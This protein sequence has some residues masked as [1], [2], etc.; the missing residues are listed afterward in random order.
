MGFLKCVVINEG[1]FELYDIYKVIFEVMVGYLFYSE[2]DIE[3]LSDFFE[4]ADKFVFDFDVQK[5]VMNMVGMFL[6]F[7][8]DNKEECV[9]V[10]GCFVMVFGFDNCYIK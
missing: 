5:Q 3:L 6:F 7:E 8:E 4:G 9:D 1:V 10:F 2:I